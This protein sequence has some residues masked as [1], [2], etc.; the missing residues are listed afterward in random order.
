MPIKPYAKA[1]KGS[2]EAFSP[3]ARAR[4]V[5]FALPWHPTSLAQTDSRNQTRRM[6]GERRGDRQRK[7]SGLAAYSGRC[8]VL[9]PRQPGILSIDR[10]RIGGDGGRRS[11]VDARAR[12]K[13]HRTRAPCRRT[14][15][16]ASRRRLTL[17]MVFFRGRRVGS[18]PLHHR[19][20]GGGA[21]GRPRGNPSRGS[22]SGRGARPL[23][24]TVRSTQPARHPLLRRVATA[25]RRTAVL[26]DCAPATPD[27]P[28][29]SDHPRVR[30][31]LARLPGSLPRA[32]A[33][34]WGCR[35]LPLDCATDP[36]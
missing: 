15:A 31:K 22:R 3:R 8:C 14:N 1:A 7:R 27:R 36:S 5:L 24:R 20:R 2:S 28:L 26:G 23:L 9:V 12:R 11:A 32:S 35:P 4:R 30:P 19:P 18:L 29:H 21:L 10:K 34:S 13:P 17:G 33:R 6:H 25:H 16:K